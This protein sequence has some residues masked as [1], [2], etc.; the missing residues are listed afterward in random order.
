VGRDKVQIGGKFGHDFCS[1]GAEPPSHT[2]RKQDLSPRCMRT[3]L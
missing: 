2:E 3:A 1:G